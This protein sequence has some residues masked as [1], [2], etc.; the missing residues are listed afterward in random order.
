MSERIP[1]EVFPPGEYIRDEL[2]ERGWSQVELAEILGVSKATVSDLIRAKRAVTPEVAKA[3]EAA[4]GP[5]AR[6]WLALDAYYRLH[7]A[8]AVSPK[9]SVRARLREKYPVRDLIQAHAGRQFR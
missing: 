7:T 6:Y 4:L 1:A 3:L 5:S 2:E 9:I 8:P